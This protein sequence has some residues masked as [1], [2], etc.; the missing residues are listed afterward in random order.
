MSIW[1]TVGTGFDNVHGDRPHLHVPAGLGDVG[2]GRPSPLVKDSKFWPRRPAWTRDERCRAAR[3]YPHMRRRPDARLSISVTGS[4]LRLGCTRSRRVA[5][6]RDVEP[7]VAL[8]QRAAPASRGAGACF[9]TQ[10]ARVS[11]AQ[12]TTA[13]VPPTAT[14]LRE[15]AC[16]IR[17]RT[18]AH[19]RQ[20]R[21]GCQTRVARSNA[22]RA[23]GHRI[24]EAPAATSCKT[25]DVSASGVPSKLCLSQTSAASH[26]RSPSLNALPGGG[27]R[28]RSP[29]RARQDRGAGADLSSPAE[30]RRRAQRRA[31]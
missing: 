11:E 23:R 20:Q 21:K 17:T 22:L 27:W 24:C 28:P 1:P 9:S 30:K 5:V 18:Q 15:K 26:E 8:E 12:V 19:V 25:A 7:I 3:S 6:E 4:A 2:P 16:A 29:A 13:G 31:K 10:T 14:F